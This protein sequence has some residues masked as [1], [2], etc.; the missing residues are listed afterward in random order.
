MAKHGKSNNAKRET[1]TAANKGLAK[2]GRT[3][4]YCPT[5]AWPRN[6]M[7]YLAT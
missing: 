5:I 7:C 6:V 1:K 4:F 2:V 3:E